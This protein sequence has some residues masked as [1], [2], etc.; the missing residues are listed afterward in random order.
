MATTLPRASQIMSPNRRALDHSVSR[1]I[2]WGHRVLLIVA[3]GV[4]PLVACE[5]A[6]PTPTSDL[7]SG[8]ALVDLNAQLAQFRED[9]A[10]LQAQ[11][12]S[13]RGALAYQDTILRQVAAGA[14]IPM[15]PPAV[16]IP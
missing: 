11:I 12:D 16:P 14:G 3:F 15:R 7:T 8:Q 13:L 6:I 2:S 10:L 1:S 4:G 5:T 9:N